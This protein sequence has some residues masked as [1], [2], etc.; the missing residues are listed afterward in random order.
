[1]FIMFWDF[2][3]VEQSFL[4]PQVKRSMIIS[5]K[6]GTYELCNEPEMTILSALVKILWK[7]E[8]E[9]SHSAHSAPP[10]TKTRTCTE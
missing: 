10:H 7:A 5:N 9:P 4:S 6:H 3:I 1:M 2:F 8:I